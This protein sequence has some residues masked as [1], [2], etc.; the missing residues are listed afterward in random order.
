MAEKHSLNEF[1][2]LPALV[3]NE[4]KNPEKKA[5]KSGKKGEKIRKK[6]GDFVGFLVQMKSNPKKPKRTL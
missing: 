6:T 2:E 5:K 1:Y 4:R 3:L